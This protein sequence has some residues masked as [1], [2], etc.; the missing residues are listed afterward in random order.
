VKQKETKT[1]QVFCLDFF[2]HFLIEILGVFWDMKSLLNMPFLLFLDL[3]HGNLQ[4]IMIK[5]WISMFQ[6]KNNKNGILR[7]SWF[8]H[9]RLRHWGEFD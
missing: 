7:R 5:Q 6:I 8:G 9:F 2:R 4:K 1:I 3:K